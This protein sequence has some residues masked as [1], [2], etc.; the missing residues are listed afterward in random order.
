MNLLA[1]T[2]GMIRIAADVDSNI[3]GAP[4]VLSRT[5]FAFSLAMSAL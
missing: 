1:S 3:D 2:W 4:G 5:A